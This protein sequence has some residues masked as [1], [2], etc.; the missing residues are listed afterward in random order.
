MDVP[1]HC[2]GIGITPMRSILGDLASRRVR[3]RST[4]L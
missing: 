1:H 4:L 2:R 3:I